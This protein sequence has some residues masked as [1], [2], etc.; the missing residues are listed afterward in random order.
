MFNEC[1]GARNRFS[2]AGSA[3]ES[4]G[5][6]KKFQNPADGSR[7]EGLAIGGCFWLVFKP[8]K[9]PL[10][11]RCSG[12]LKQWHAIPCWVFQAISAFSRPPSGAVVPEVRSWQ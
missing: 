4:R 11:D 9:I 12:F 6:L 3:L 10:Y 8:H 5:S 1:T 7:R 2:N